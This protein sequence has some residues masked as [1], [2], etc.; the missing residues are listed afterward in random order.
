MEARQRN[1]NIEGFHHSDYLPQPTSDQ[2]I[3]SDISIHEAKMA[4]PEEYNVKKQV[5]HPA[6]F[7]QEEGRTMVRSGQTPLQ[8]GTVQ[9]GLG[10]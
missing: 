1:E 9:R 5:A 10:K 7:I 8:S 2:G 4:Y 6:G 3:Y